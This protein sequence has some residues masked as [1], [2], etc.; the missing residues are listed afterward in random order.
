MV[1]SK[2]W[3]RN[4]PKFLLHFLIHIDVLMLC[5]KFELI[6]TENF[7]V[8]AIFKKQ[9]IFKKYH[10]HASSKSPLIV[11]DCNL[12][13]SLVLT[14]KSYQTR[15]IGEMVN[16]MSIDAHRFIETL[17]YFHMIWS[18]PLQIVVALV[19]LYWTMGLAILAGLAV[20]LLLLPFTL[21]VFLLGQKFQ[22]KLMKAK[23]KR[24]R[25]IYGVLSGIKVISFNCY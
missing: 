1:F 3:F 21:L 17:S 13:Q 5:R 6:P 24:L 23:D 18:G 8:M 9:Q 22:T 15:T 19:V 20:L 12:S 11:I 25:S 10:A 16:L 2:K 4:H 14:R 7:C